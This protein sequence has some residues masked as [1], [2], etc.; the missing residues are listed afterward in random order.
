M[1]NY[2]EVNVRVW[3]S[4][5]DLNYNFIQIQ[6]F[7]EFYFFVFLYFVISKQHISNRLL[8]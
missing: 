4:S 1:D 5:K 8:K 2:V 7:K 6:K 3:R